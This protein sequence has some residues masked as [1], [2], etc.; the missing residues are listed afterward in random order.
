MLAGTVPFDAEST[1]GVLM[2]HLNEPPPPIAGISSDLQYIIDRALAKDPAIRFD[3]AT[4]LATE[5]IGVFN[6][7]TVSV[8]TL[9]FATLARKSIQGAKKPPQLWGLD[10]NL[11]IIGIFVL[12]GFALVAIR[13]FSPGPAQAR[14]VGQVA[15]TDFVGFMDQSTIT[16]TDLPYPEAGTHYEA[17]FLAQ[18][19]EERRNSGVVNMETSGQGKLLFTDQG[20]GNLLGTYDQIEITIEPDNDPEPAESSGEIVASS[21]FPPLALIHVRHLDNAFGGAPEETALLQGLW[22]TAD[23]IATSTEEMQ[24]AFAAGDEPLFRKKTEEVI[25][26]IVGNANTV[27]YKDWNSDGTVDDPGDGYGLAGYLPSSISHARFAAEAIDATQN[28]QTNSRYVEISAKNV[29]GWSVQLLNKALQ[30]QDMRFDS[31]LEP[32]ITEM[33]TLAKQSVTGVD[34]NNNNLIEPIVGEGG[35]NTAYENGYNMAVMPLLQGAHQL[36][37]PAQPAGK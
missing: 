17:W 34:S 30:L 20:A 8:N 2:K 14:P 36:P 25:N 16:I 29:D 32:V 12:I 31:S 4:Q 24:K 7:Q 6:G 28:I 9:K 19:G 21:V 5:F 22:F 1:F 18:G 33:V 15:F 27:Q 37:P 23:G 26:Q 35:A 3:S 13:W 10:R 11:V